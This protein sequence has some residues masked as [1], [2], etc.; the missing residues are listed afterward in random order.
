MCMHE[1]F[2]WQFLPEGGFRVHT[3]S[4]MFLNVIEFEYIIYEP[5]NGL[6]L[7]VVFLNVLEKYIYIHFI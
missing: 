7:I 2:R 4:Q 1:K 5:L 3:D 6:E